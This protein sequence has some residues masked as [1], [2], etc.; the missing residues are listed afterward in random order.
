MLFR[1]NLVVSSFVFAF[2]VYRYT[3]VRVGLKYRYETESIPLYYLR[4]GWIAGVTLTVARHAP[5][6]RDPCGRPSMPSV[7]IVASVIQHESWRAPRRTP[8]RVPA[9]H[10]PLPPPYTALGLL[11]ATLSTTICYN[12]TG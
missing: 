9:P 2:S 3:M 4:L 1:S 7:H 10:P 5:A 6:C 8:T 12:T 11:I